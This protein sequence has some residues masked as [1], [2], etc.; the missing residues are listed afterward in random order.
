MRLPQFEKDGALGFVNL[1]TVRDIIEPH[2]KAGAEANSCAVLLERG[3]SVTVY[4]SK[5]CVKKRLI[6]GQAA[7]NFFLRAR[8]IGQRRG[9]SWSWRVRAEMN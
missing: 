5:K 3:L 8:A 7:K 2:E 9:R 4:Y 6:N 1:C